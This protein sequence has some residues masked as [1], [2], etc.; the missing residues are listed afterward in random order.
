M[1]PNSWSY[2]FN[3]FFLQFRFDFRRSL[4]NTLP[5]ISKR[6]NSQWFKSS[7]KK[8]RKSKWK[9]KSPI[10]CC[11][12]PRILLCLGVNTFMSKGH[13]SDET[14]A[15]QGT[16]GRGRSV[17]Q[18][19]MELFGSLSSQIDLPIINQYSEYECQI[20]EL[21]IFIHRHLYLYLCTYDWC[22]GYL[23]KNK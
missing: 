9:W 4:K 14:E 15:D 8:R 6:M 1:D 11:L 20:Y 3:T 10:S 18:R 13:C 7:R 12:T 5:L 16:R 19:K 17:T 21:V 2:Q 23:L 22:K